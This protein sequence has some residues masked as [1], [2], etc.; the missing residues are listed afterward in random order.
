MNVKVKEILIPSDIDFM[1]KLILWT[2]VE[3][4]S[5]INMK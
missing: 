4:I 2:A 3:F 5:G 1:Y